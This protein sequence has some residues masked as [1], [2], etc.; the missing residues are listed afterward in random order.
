MNE[1]LPPRLLPKIAYAPLQILLWAVVPLL[2]LLWVNYGNY[3]TIVGDLESADR[4]V[5]I[6]GLLGD[7]GLAIGYGIL[8]A[9]LWFRR[10]EVSVSLAIAGF[11]PII[12]LIHYSVWELPGTIPSAAQ[13]IISPEAVVIQNLTGVMPAILYFGA[14]ICGGR[15]RSVAVEMGKALLGM[16]AVGLLVGLC[17]AVADFG[18]EVGA[19]VT[20][21]LAILVCTFAVLRLLILA[22]NAMFRWSPMALTLIGLW[23]GLLLPIIGLWVNAFVPFPYDFQLPWVYAFA[24]ANGVL[25][26]IPLPANPAGRRLVWF[27]Q[28]AGLPFTFYFFVVFLPFLPLSVPGLMI[29]GGGLLVLVPACVLLLHGFR[30]VA[31]FRKLRSEASG[32]LRWG[33]AFAAL[34][35]VPG[36][37]WWNA[38]LD[39]MVLHKALDFVYVASPHNSARF[40]GD[41]ALLRRTLAH[42][43]EFK[44]GKKL[45]MISAFYN[46]AVFDGLTLPDT[47]IKQLS[48][49]F[50]GEEIELKSDSGN[51]WG[52]G[53]GFANQNF[54]ISDPPHTDVS[55]LPVNTSYRAEGDRFVRTTAMLKMENKRS[56]QGE[57]T[58]TLTLPKNAAVS[59]FWLHIGNERVPG[60]MTEKKA[61]MWVYQM[62]RDVTRRDP[63]ILRY[64]APD[65]LELRVFPLAGHEI[66]TVELSFSRRRRLNNR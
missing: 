19:I 46:D 47:K 65:Q 57:F 3:Q 36:A 27:A 6:L 28:C 32:L 30:V 55:L 33:I 26:S 43:Q 48:Q 5:W 15:G 18:F 11:V 2:F 38:T 34:A 1:S 8:A 40:D 60:R 14:V 39:R 63:G 29:W 53:R 41:T 59:G 13:W 49:T 56:E 23:V 31:G 58:G 37:V 22:G 61:S 16:V 10:S 7:A 4:W 12:A 35:I 20:M 50:L 21:T 25:L 45:P 17:A 62:I 9:V 24:A 42:V 66:R 64:T 54:R 44:A 51:L 52:R